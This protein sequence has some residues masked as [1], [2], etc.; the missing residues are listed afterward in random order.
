M[1]DAAEDIHVE[2]YVK[3]DLVLIADG[4][5]DYYQ[6]FDDIL[7]SFME[8]KVQSL[9]TIKESDFTLHHDG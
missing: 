5:E 1:K 4:K 6:Q 9:H 3:G 2:V 8:R 7:H